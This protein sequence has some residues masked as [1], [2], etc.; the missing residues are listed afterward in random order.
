MKSKDFD[1]N[2]QSLLIC[3]LLIA[4]GYNNQNNGEYI[5]SIHDPIIS[6]DLFF[7]VQNILNGKKPNIVPK[8]KNN[9]LFPLR[10]YIYIVQ[11]AEEE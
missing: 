7:S 11:N 8:M 10:Q 6:K 4:T 2:K 3:I 1:I 9:P 5:Q